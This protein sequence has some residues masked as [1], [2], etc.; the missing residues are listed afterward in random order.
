[1]PSSVQ[2]EALKQGVQRWKDWWKLHQQ[3]YPVASTSPA[4]TVSSW[5]LPAPDFSL[6]DLDGKPI[7]LAALKG[8]LVLINFWD[9]V[10][11][12]CLFEI[13]VLNELQKKNSNRL[14][15]LAISL[16]S[17]AQ[18]RSCESCAQEHDHASHSPPKPNLG[19]IRAQVQQIAKT[20]G[21][22][23]PVL[24]DPTGSVGRRFIGDDLPSYILIQ[25]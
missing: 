21:I 15:V 1:M 23:C 11:T 2:A 5:R 9:T 24:I 8:K 13:P 7:R 18:E 10:T 12:N 25:R 14:V 16:D 22:T 20:R 4:Q 19:T 17:T 3:K 6:E